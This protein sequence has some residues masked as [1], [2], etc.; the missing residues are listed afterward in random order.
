MMEVKTGFYKKKSAGITYEQIIREV[1]A[2]SIRPVYYLMGEESYYID[3]IADFLVDSVLQPEERDFNLITF[4]G[5]DVDIDTVITAAKSYPMGSSHLVIVVKEAQNLKQIDRLE[6][7]F[8]QM[9]PSTTL[10]FCHKNGCLDRRTK[11]ATLINKEG[12]LFESKRLYDNQLPTFVRDYM[13]RKKIGIDVEA[14]E[15]VSSFIGSD[16]NRIASELD[17]LILALPKGEKKVTRDL[18]LSHI[19]ISK[20]FN[21][22]ELQD[23]IV[24][25]DVLKAN[26]IINYFEKNAK[27]YPIQKVLPSLFKYFSNL[28]LSFY[29][30]DKTESG[31]ALWLG[32]T[33]WQVRKNIH[34]A[35][36]IYTG[37]KVMQILSEI[38]RTDAR[39]KGVGN[40]AISNGDLMKELLFFILH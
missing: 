20:E 11:I 18:V 37:V 9:Q 6:Y 17:K 15:V 2:G 34:P 38:R 32:I 27:E 12:V 35:M 30:P 14:S 10:I 21:V 5:L 8:R 40:S 13:K 33:E 16:L 26:R 31:L 28:M 19:G 25:H 3:R 7:Y 4:Y 1:R 24:T 22:F 39:S 23:A 29:S 36:S